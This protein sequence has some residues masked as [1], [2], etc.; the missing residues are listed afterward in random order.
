[1]YRCRAGRAAH[2]IHDGI[3]KICRLFAEIAAGGRSVGG[4]TGRC[5]GGRRTEINT[6]ASWCR[7]LAARSSQRRRR[8]NAVSVTDQPF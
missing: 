7:E 4:H 2:A 6:R 8:A 1:V 5:W 3:I